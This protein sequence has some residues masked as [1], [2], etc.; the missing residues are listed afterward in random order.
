MIGSRCIVPCCRSITHSCHHAAE[1]SH[2]HATMLQ[3]HHIHVTMLQKHHIHVTMLQKHHVHFPM[4]KLCT[5]QFSQRP[6]LKSVSEKH[7]FLKHPCTEKSEIDIL[8][9]TSQ[10]FVE[11]H[12]DTDLRNNV[13]VEFLFN[14]GQLVKTSLLVKAS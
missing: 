11:K 14:Q 5:D 13:S 8:G 6:M 4:L 1:A 2:I 10:D 3:K 9:R 12:G 7:F